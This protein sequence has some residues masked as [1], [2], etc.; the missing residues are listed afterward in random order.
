MP[1]QAALKYNIARVNIYGM[2]KLEFMIFVLYPALCGA[3]EVR[4]HIASI[5]MEFVEY[6]AALEWW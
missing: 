2:Y 1:I 5:K 6:Y 3:N 4:R